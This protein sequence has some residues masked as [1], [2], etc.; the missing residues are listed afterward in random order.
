MAVVFDVVDTGMNKAMSA[1][2]R[3][4]HEERVPI[5]RIPTAAEVA[6]QIA[7]VIENR[8]FLLSGATVTLSGGALPW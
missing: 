6:D 8:S 1:T 3:L 7:W 5:G 2:V 4:A